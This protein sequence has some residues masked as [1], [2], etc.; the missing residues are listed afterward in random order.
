MLMA[1]GLVEPN[2]AAAEIVVSTGSI[3]VRCV[4]KKVIEIPMK[5]TRTNCPS[6]FRTY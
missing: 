1:S 6:R 2:A 4:T 5:T 3:G